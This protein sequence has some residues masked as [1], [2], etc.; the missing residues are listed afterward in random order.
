MTR[1][2]DS[3]GGEIKTPISLVLGGITKKNTGDTVRR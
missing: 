3:I 2:D 1:D